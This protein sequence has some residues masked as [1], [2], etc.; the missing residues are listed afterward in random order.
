MQLSNPEP[1][2]MS[3]PNPK[4]SEISR[5]DSANPAPTTPAPAVDICQECDRE[6]GIW[7]ADHAVWNEAVGGDPHREAGGLL[8]PSCFIARATAAGIAS[9]WKVVPDESVDPIECE[10]C[11]AHVDDVPLEWIDTPHKGWMFL[12][13]AP[14][15]C[16]DRFR[17]LRFRGHRRV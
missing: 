10:V 7:W 9:R 15:A 3:T 11:G 14:L 8:C 13:A 6:Y 17:G 2:G 5:E 1:V 16:L 4:E 12:C